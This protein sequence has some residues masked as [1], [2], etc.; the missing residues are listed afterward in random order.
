MNSIKEICSRIESL[1]NEQNTEE[2][3]EKLLRVLHNVKKCSGCKSDLARSFSYFGCITI[4]CDKCLWGEDFYYDIIHVGITKKERET[5]FRELFKERAR[6]MFFCRCDKCRYPRVFT[7]VLRRNTILVSVDLHLNSIEGRGQVD[8]PKLE[9]LMGGCVDITSGQFYPKSE[10][11]DEYYYLKQE[12]QK[13]RD[14]ID[15]LS[16]RVEKL[17]KK[18]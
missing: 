9:S 17:E 18:T 3:K 14:L 11:F 15:D 1:R 12:N 2:Y 13:L 6:N 7:R 16:R 5:D 8:V 10:I 4:L